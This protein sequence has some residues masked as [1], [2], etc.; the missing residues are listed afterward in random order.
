[1]EQSIV[2]IIIVAVVFIVAV[3]YLQTTQNSQLGIGGDGPLATGSSDSA[4]QNPQPIGTAVPSGGA[5]GSSDT[6]PQQYKIQGQ[7]D[8]KTGSSGTVQPKSGYSRYESTVIISR[9]QRSA[10][11]AKEYATIRNGSFFNRGDAAVSLDGWT[12]ESRRSGRVAIPKA[13]ALPFIDAD[14]GPIVLLPGE[15]ALITSGATTFG[16]SFRENS[17][18]G[19]FA[20]N[21]SFTPSLASCTAVPFDARDLLDR[22][23]NSDCVDFV[24]GIARCRI[25]TIPFE[26]SARIGNACI[27][28]VTDTYSYAGCVARFR[29]SGGFFKKTWRAFLN[30]PSSLYDSR[31]D[32]VI[33]RDSEGLTVDEFEY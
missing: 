11:P 6:R 21:H 2:T 33:V 16:R 29:D 5:R 8:K 26:K 3:Q 13:E 24:R 12:I 9:V 15:E 17:C 30:Q 19:Y 31:H 14:A 28:Y 18:T 7:R 20:Q 27:E 4:I 23:Y 32:R 22:G 1:M 10:D 25:P